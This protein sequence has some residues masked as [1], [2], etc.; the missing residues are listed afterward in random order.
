[1]P[2]PK[3]RLLTWKEMF[4]LLVCALPLLFLFSHLG[5]PGSGHTALYCVGAIF[6]TVRWRWELSDRWWFWPTVVAVSAIHAVF[7][8]FV[9]LGDRWILAGGA[10]PIVAADAWAISALFSVIDYYSDGPPADPNLW[11]RRTRDE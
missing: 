1:M 8:W 6:I 10:A 3:R 7:A 5:R 11:A 4:I 9:P 2:E